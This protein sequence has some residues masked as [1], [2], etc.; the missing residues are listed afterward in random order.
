MAQQDVE[1]ACHVDERL[2]CVT[3]R[4]C[5]RVLPRATPIHAAD[6][7]CCLLARGSGVWRAAWLLLSSFFS[8]VFISQDWLKARAHAPSVA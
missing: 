5:V 4:A 3:W 8:D 7:A 2:G 6:A 1:F